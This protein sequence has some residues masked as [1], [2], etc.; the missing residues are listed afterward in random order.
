MREA[1]I[2]AG[3]RTPVGKAIRGQ[4]AHLRPENMAITVIKALIE[5]LGNTFDADQID[6]VVMGCAMPEGAQGLNIARIVSLGAGLPA[7]V[8]G[9]TVN[10]FCSSGL[11]AIAQASHAIMAGQ[12]E[13]VLAA[14]VESMSAVPM[15]GFHFSP[16]SELVERISDVYLP[17]GLTAEA[18]ADEYNISREDQDQFA[19]RSHQRAMTAMQAGRFDEQLVPLAWQE[20]ILDEQGALQTLEQTLAQDENVRPDTSL[21]G[22]S[23]LKPAFKVGGSVT[24]GNASPLSDGAAAVMIMERNRA[25]AMGLVP[26]LRYVASA[27]AGVNPRIMGIG[28]VAA[29]PKALKQAGLQLSDIDL[30]E[31][32]E[33]FAAQ[34]LA[35]IRALALNEEIVNVNGGAIA[36]GHPL[37][38][39]GCKLT[40]QLMYE[41]MARQARYGMV[42]MCVGGGQ[43]MAGIFERITH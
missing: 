11:Q 35:V 30:I 22:L 29:V 3:V 31:L 41:L 38:A 4:T 6:D 15:T 42:T 43:G 37:G 8:P 18:V 23:Q 5:R 14:G 7:S 28:P 17:M 27:A 32:N 2:V 34:S 36:L 9:V 21:Q 16:D 33:A 12:A 39:T 40:V 24:P 20:Q 1:V 13:I 10:R 25:E 19:L 26:R